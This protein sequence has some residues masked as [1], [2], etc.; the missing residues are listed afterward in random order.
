MEH[1]FG[2]QK[3]IPLP[4]FQSSSQLFQT[5]KQVFKKIID[6]EPLFGNDVAKT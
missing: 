3:S 4:Y 2:L 6:P 1:Y 5:S